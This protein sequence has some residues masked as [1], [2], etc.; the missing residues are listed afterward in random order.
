[1]AMKNGSL[2]HLILSLSLAITLLG[3]G[4]SPAVVMIGSPYDRYDHNRTQKFVVSPSPDQRST[5]ILI[6]ADEVYS[7]FGSEYY[8]SVRDKEDGPRAD[9]LP[10]ANIVPIFTGIPLPLSSA[11]LGEGRSDRDDLIDFL[12]EGPLAQTGV[13]PSNTMG[14]RRSTEEKYRPIL[15]FLGSGDQLSGERK[16]I[17]DG[18]TSLKAGIADK[19]IDA[20]YR[21]RSFADVLAFHFEKFWFVLYKLPGQSSYSRLVVAPAQVKVQD[22]PEKGL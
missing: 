10:E 3:A 16:Q 1:M 14:D 9:D 17:I 11:P 6:V 21:L 4:C 15:D 5:G 22:F 19:I 18:L 13:Q 2:R 12:A 7:P 8:P 20:R